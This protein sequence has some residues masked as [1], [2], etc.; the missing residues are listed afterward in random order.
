MRVSSIGDHVSIQ[1]NGTLLLFN[2]IDSGLYRIEPITRKLLILIKKYGAEAAKTLIKEEDIDNVAEEKIA[3]LKE[4]NFLD[5]SPQFT[6]P[7]TIP[8]TCASFNISHACN[9]N[10]RYCFG[11]STYVGERSHM[12][13][14]IGELAVD[15]LL[16]WSNG[17]KLVYIALFGGEPLLNMKLVKHLVHYGKERAEAE[18]KKILFSMTCNGTLLTDA[19]IDYLNVNNVK[20]MVSMDGPPEVQ[21]VNRP[22]KNGRGSYSTIVSRVQK[23]L[24]TRSRVT[25]RATLTKDC[26]SLETIV[27]G[28][29]EV[30]FTYVHVE[31][32]TADQTCSFALSEQDFEILKTE[33][34]RLGTLLLEN[35]AQDTPFGFSNILRTISSIYNSGVRHYPCGAGKNLV[36]I[37]SHGSIYLCHR[38]TGMEEFSMGTLADPDFS[39]QKKI[40]QNHVDSRES[41]KDC[42]ARHLCGGGCWQ[43]NYIYSGRID[44]PYNPKCSLFKHIAALSMIIFSKLHQ[45]DKE[46]LDNMFKKNEPLYKRADLPEEKHE[47]REGR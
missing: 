34:D 22:F 8:I 11:G 9:L 28:L 10:C 35:I 1:E 32:V 38:F 7:D 21:N 31:P 4:N 17:S 16:E 13:S 40:L 15:R 6:P 24:S 5:P 23:L 29:R 25:A 37:G 36:A 44:K 18:G 33:Y 42:W 46:L 14:E 41:C 20:V 3:E 39:L 47:P 30:G 43:D 2:T 12:S 19:I 45:R 26:L 27:N